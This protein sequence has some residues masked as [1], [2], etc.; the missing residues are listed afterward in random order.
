MAVRGER[1]LE[2]VSAQPRAVH[3]A[4]IGIVVHEQQTA[5]RSRLSVALAKDVVHT[6]HRGRGA[7]SV[8]VTGAG[9][10]PDAT[11]VAGK[12][13]DHFLT[14]RS[15]RTVQAYMIDLDD[16]ARFLRTSRSDATAR[17][18]AGG[19]GVARRVALEYAIYLRRRSR[20]AN[21]IDRRLN[22]LRALIRHANELGVIEWQ[23]QLPSDDDIAAEM[24]RLPANDSEHYLLPRHL[25]EI[26]RLDI[27]HYA[28]RE[29]LRANH[30]APVEEAARVLDVGCG[31]GQWA[32][33]MCAEFDSSL[34]VGLDLVS[35]KSAQP[36]GYWYVRG[37]VLHGLPFADDRFDFVHQRFLVSG[38]PL[39]CWSE[40]VSDLAR[41]ARPGGWVELVEVPWSFDRPGPASQRIMDL[42]RPL[43][44]SLELDTS[45]VVYRSLD[46]YLREAGLANVAR[47]E[48]TKPI[49]RWGGAVGSLMVTNLRAGVTRV[50][51]ILQARGMLSADELRELIQEALVEWE[52]GQMAYPVAVA[53]GQKPPR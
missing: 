20:A 26:D 34:V 24:E 51:E 21:T 7:G 42:A 39:A 36:P 31:T 15:D 19:V 9:I 45:D 48:V 2:A 18:L 12:L 10:D 5:L 16:F 53:F 25:A 29:T 28:M 37:D 38:L 43:L 30:L 52:N 41:V 8:A 14:D 44:A 13:L 23:L 50:C 1:H 33:E 3:G 47:H 11:L 6:G 49:G 32:F 35:G 46:G 22:T 40:V 27:Q 17:L 4:D